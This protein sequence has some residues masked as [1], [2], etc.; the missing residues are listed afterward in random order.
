MS[1]KTVVILGGSYTGL[2]TAHK[3][4]KHTYP[5]TK[6]FKVILV[7]NTSHWYWNF[8][9]PRAFMPDTIPDE[10]LFYP[11]EP[12]LQKYPAEAWE[13][14]HGSAEKLDPKAKTV[15]I[16]LQDGS[17]RSVS[18]DLAVLATGSTYVNDLG[19]KTINGDYEAT[20][21]ALHDTQARIK[22]ASSVVVAGAGA[23]GTETAA[24][25]G[26]KFGKDEQKKITWILG[27]PR[28]VPEFRA[29]VGSTAESR[30]KGWGVEII[31]D[32]KITETVEKDG[33][34]ELTLSDGKTITTDFY[35]P[36][37]GLR[38]N[39]SYVPKELLDDQG[40]VKV[41]NR[42]RVEGFTD[43][44]AIGD[45]SNKEPNVAI[46]AEGQIAFIGPE[47]DG[48]LNGKET[49][50][51]KDFS[52]MFSFTVGA[53]TLGPEGGTGQMGWFKMPSIAVYYMKARDM[54]TSKAPAYIAGVKS[55]G[56]NI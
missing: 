30:I 53:V 34:F 3:L 10:K 33:K 9:A 7:S 25:L 8:A 12:E 46:H 42:L 49:G 54:S 35:I 37:F 44:Y 47:L 14:V 52:P 24:E 11:I 21:K 16:K 28:G 36:A 43:L 31:A 22:A 5:K 23:C 50:A 26:Y 1:T 19:W 13:F 56:G 48:L 17:T 41:D 55:L 2:T 29:D 40:Y 38:P 27:G 20:K 6:T 4:L 32:T 51:G 18:Y 15:E 39:S 45:V